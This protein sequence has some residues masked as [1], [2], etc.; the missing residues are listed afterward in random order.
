MEASEQSEVKNFIVVDDDSAKSLFW[1]VALKE[2]WPAAKV[3]IFNGGY[4]AVDWAM[5]NKGEFFVGNWDAKPMSGLIFMQRVRGIGKYKHTPFLIFSRQLQEEDIELARE[6]GVTNT[7][8][9]AFD[10]SK[11]HE[12]IA[13]MMSE[14]SK[15]DPV[16]RNLR[17][18]EDWNAANKT[19]ESFKLIASVM[20]KPGAYAARAFTAQ[21]DLYLRTE[22]YE[23]AEKSF[24]EALKIDGNY[25]PAMSGLGKTY[26][27][28]KKFK[29]ATAQFEI[30]HQKQPKNIERMMNLGDAYL[31]SGDTAKA[32][33]VF[34]GAKALDEG[35]PGAAEGLG[36]VAF[37]GGNLE[38]ATQFFKES[39]KGDEL[40]SY[41]NNSAISLVNQGRVD[42]AIGLY[43]N[44]IK[45]LPARDKVHLL[46]FN[47]GLA[48]KKREQFGLAAEAFARSL[49]SSPSYEKSY[50]ALAECLHEAKKRAQAFDVA[51]I[52]K[53]IL[54][55]RAAHPDA[56]KAS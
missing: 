55:Y 9:G 33:E 15:L 5:K 18:I 13:A 40:A 16:L 4:E 51:T 17:K 52:E 38:L 44:A 32:A 46:E 23:Q 34:K 35:N 56:N 12:M 30:M 43:K 24:L 7:L 2:K 29:E 10:K 50:S 21:G 53:S 31:T 36:K 45:V 22:R 41:F 47:I 6:F 3:N 39:G 48:H 19:T 25:S 8:V 27:R 20:A 42:D 14:E 1:E 11:V 28:Q 49:L 26:L 37:H 54:A